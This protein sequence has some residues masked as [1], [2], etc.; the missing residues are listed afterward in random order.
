MLIFRKAL[1]KVFDINY[2]FLTV[3]ERDGVNVLALGSSTSQAVIVSVLHGSGMAILSLANILLDGLEVG[4]ESD[5]KRERFLKDLLNYLG[6]T[7]SDPKKFV[8][9]NAYLFGST[10]V[11]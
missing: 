7:C 2:L 3:E 10:E 1:N 8:L 6:L 5:C 4:S 9:T 11:L